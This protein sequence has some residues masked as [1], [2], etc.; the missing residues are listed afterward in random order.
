M[1]PKRSN[2]ILSSHIPDIKF[3]ILVRDGLDVEA[4]GRD[5]CDVGIELQL[6]EDCYRSESVGLA[7]TFVDGS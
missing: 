3:D 5:S 2:L 4:N 1:P 6:V 7:R